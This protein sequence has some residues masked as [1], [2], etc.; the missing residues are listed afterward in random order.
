MMKPDISQCTYKNVNEL[1]HDL[2][3]LDVSILLNEYNFELL[4]EMK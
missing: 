3:Y 4:N 2:I 1:L